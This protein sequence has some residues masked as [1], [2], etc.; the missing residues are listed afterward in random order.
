MRRRT[1]FELKKAKERAHILEG[2]KIAVDN[3]DE[4]IQIIRSSKSIPEARQRLTERFG[5]DD[6]QTQAIVQ[7]P[8]GRLTGLERE[9]LEDELAGL[10]VKI[11]DYEDILANE[12]PRACNREAGS[13]RRQGEIRRRPPHRD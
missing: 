12:E 13:H 2:L 10:R 11:A 9:K 4:V 7:M 1:A 6:V 5:L 8:L 3:I